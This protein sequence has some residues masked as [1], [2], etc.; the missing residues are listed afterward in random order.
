MSKDCEDKSQFLNPDEVN[1]IK[2]W[3]KSDESE[4]ESS[5]GDVEKKYLRKEVSKEIIVQEIQEEDYEIKKPNEMILS[6]RDFGT[7]KIN[8]DFDD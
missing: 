4:S 1:I 7:K 3:I 6:I 2:E 5:R 8:E